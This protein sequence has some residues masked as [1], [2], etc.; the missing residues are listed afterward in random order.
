MLE[1]PHRRGQPGEAERRVEDD[2]GLARA[3]A[4][5]LGRRRPGSA[6]RGRRSASSRRSPATSSSSRLRRD[7]LERLAT[8]RAGRTEQGYPRHALSVPGF[9]RLGSC[10]VIHL[11]AAH[12]ALSA[13]SGDEE[14]TA[15]LDD[16]IQDAVVDG[17]DWANRRA[18]R[19]QIRRAE[20]RNTRLTGAELGESAITDVVFADCRLDLAGLRNATLERVIFRDCRME[21]CDFYA[22]RLS[23]V[24]FER[25]ML[26]SGDVLGSDP[27]A[28]RAARL[29]PGGTPRRGAA[30]RRPPALSGR[31]R[32]RH[33]LRDRR[34]ASS[35][36][37][38]P[39][40]ASQFG[41]GGSHPH[42]S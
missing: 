37:T 1:R 19:A 3:P 29:R 7:H 33:P 17:A 28:G 5:P 20:L 12:R 18:P 11:E 25:C 34:S 39:R 24:L 38:D 2:V 22:A 14:R 40:R 32:E 15:E 27:R 10:R 13:G 36:S 6:A 26:R 9:R 30:A 21:E 16:G 41:S 42:G 35:S 4:A 31:A 23:D 8:D